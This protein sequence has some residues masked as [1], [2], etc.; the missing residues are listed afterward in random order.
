[1]LRLYKHLKP[2]SMFVSF[3]MIL[4]FLQTL[5]DLYLPTLMSDIVNNGI[6]P[7]DTGYI[8]RPAAG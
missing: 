6:L 4:V 8:L 5:A 7:G 2:F 3:V 1:M